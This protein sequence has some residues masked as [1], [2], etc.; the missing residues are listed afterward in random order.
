MTPVRLLLLASLVLAATPAG[1]GTLYKCT[2]A[3]GIP[4]DSQFTYIIG[5]MFRW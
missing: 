1:A 4:D 2:G 3:D 5:T